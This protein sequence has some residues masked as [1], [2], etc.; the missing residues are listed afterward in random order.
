MLY[1]RGRVRSTDV[2]HPAMMEKPPGSTQLLMYGPS[3]KALLAVWT[4]S[5]MLSTCTGKFLSS[6]RSTRL[7]IRMLS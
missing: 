6:A 1:S 7:W 5:D 3:L 2:P 4:A